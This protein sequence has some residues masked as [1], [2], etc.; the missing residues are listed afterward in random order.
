MLL[1]KDFRKVNRV[2]KEQWA[3]RPVDDEMSL[4]YKWA[5]VEHPHTDWERVLS[6]HEKYED[7]KKVVDRVDDGL[8][9]L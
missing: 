5:V 8:D 1:I 9:L 2:A 7:A 6:C 3:G 4:K